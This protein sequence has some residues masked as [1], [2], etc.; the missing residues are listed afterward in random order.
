M[1]KLH[2]PRLPGLIRA[3][4]KACSAPAGK[5]RKVRNRRSSLPRAPTKVR[6]QTDLPTL[7]PARQPFL[8]QGLRVSAASR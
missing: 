5:G 6:L 2:L 4:W 1:A 8:G 7:A 3:R